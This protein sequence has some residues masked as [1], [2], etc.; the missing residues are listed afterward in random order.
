MQ[1]VHHRIKQTIYVRLNSICMMII[2]VVKDVFVINESLNATGIDNFAHFHNSRS[3][4]GR[5]GHIF[6]V[7][8]DVLQASKT[9]V[10]Q[11]VQLTIQMLEKALN[12]QE[13]NE[14]SVN[15]SLESM[16]DSLQQRF[17]FLMTSEHQIA[18][19]VLDPIVKLSY[20]ANAGD[21]FSRFR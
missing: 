13:F 2:S 1:T 20:R 11:K 16:T 21:N 3:F 12:A 9:S 6:K 7:A 8:T 4:F 17:S 18:P 19:A 5:I 14:R 15:A 10:I